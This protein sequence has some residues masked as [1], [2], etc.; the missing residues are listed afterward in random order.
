MDFSA[1][2]AAF[3]AAYAQARAS[4]QLERLP[5]GTREE[6][7]PWSTEPLVNRDYELSVRVPLSDVGNGTYLAQ[8]AELGRIAGRL[9]DGLLDAIEERPTGLPFYQERMEPGLYFDARGD[10]VLV[11]V[12][13][14]GAIGFRPSGSP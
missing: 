2:Q 1:I 7:Y 6:V 8:V 3:D 11:S 4:S 10:S 14:R 5:S 12:R 9:P 13:A